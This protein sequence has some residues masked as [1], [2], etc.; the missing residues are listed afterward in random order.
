MEGLFRGD[1]LAAFVGKAEYLT[2]IRGNTETFKVCDD[3]EVGDSFAYAGTSQS[4]DFVL[5]DA[6]KGS[7]RQWI[8][9][10]AFVQKQSIC[11]VLKG[12]FLLV[13][14]YAYLDSILDC[15]GRSCLPISCST[16]SHKTSCARVPQKNISTT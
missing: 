16:T 2:F 10:A 4:V 6:G 13:I 11:C 1:C 3:P 14:I 9:M 15:V 5:D 8:P 12:F 7:T